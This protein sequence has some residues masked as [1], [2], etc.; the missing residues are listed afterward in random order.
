MHC[1]NV[2]TAAADE[3]IKDVDAVREKLARGIPVEDLMP[4][5]ASLS[6]RVLIRTTVAS[7]QNIAREI[8]ERTKDADILAMATAFAATFENELRRG[9]LVAFLNNLV[10]YIERRGVVTPGG[11]IMTDGECCSSIN[12][13]KMLLYREVR[14]RASLRMVEG[15]VGKLSDG[16]CMVPVSSL[17]AMK[18]LAMLLASGVL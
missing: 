16:L 8:S 12:V 13:A 15:V 11:Y 6:N 7:A 1:P 17:S 18:T 3:V 2:V 4:D 14:D 5:L 9:M 10:R